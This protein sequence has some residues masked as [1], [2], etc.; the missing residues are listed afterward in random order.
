MWTHH[1]VTRTYLSG[2][3]LWVELDDSFWI[4]VPSGV[5]LDWL[6]HSVRVSIQRGAQDAETIRTP[7]RNRPAVALRPYRCPH[8]LCGERPIR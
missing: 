5:K 2:D 7:G 6:A 4:G 3:E 1:A 8:L